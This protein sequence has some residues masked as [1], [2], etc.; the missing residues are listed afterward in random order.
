[1]SLDHNIRLALNLLIPKIKAQ[2]QRSSQ[3]VILGITGLQGSGKSTWAD[4]IV[5]LLT[6]E[7]ELHT[8]TISLDDLYNTHEDLV[9]LR[10]TNTLYRTRGQPGTH[11]VALAAKFFKDLKEYTG[12]DGSSLQIP[13]FDKSRFNGE[14]DRAPEYEW[15]TIN[16]KPDVVV[17]EGWCLGFRPLSP[18][19][20]E[21][22]RQTSS[23]LKQ[24]RT[25]HLQEV[26]QNLAKYCEVFMGPQHFDFLIHID[27]EDLQNVYTW[28][29]QQEHALIRAK[30]SGMADAEVSAFID[31]YMPGYLLYLDGLRE[32]LF[33][34][35]KEK[36]VRIVLDK[37]REVVKVNLL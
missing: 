25:E 10:S 28:R 3:P 22:R 2:R 9:A 30:G 13:S 8:I 17:L 11:D 37:G 20:V 24:H 15:P 34:E 4:R 35:E 27:T 23:L 29:L 31:L 32:G 26:N 5:S 1:M 36:Q 7:H 6:S 14:G 33:G 12:E 19:E 18:S 16:K 21:A